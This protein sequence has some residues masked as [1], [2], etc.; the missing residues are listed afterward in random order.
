MNT[1]FRDLS[2]WWLVASGRERPVPAMP[3]PERRLDA[4]PEAQLLEALAA[5]V[6]AA[7]RVY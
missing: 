7:R 3:D 5:R 4:P 6:D 1:E 2:Q